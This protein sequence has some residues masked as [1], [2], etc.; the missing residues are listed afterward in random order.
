MYS[1]WYRFLV[2]YMF[3]RYDLSNTINEYIIIIGIITNNGN[4]VK[5]GSH[6]WL[7]S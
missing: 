4:N 3:L 2:N 7:K 5:R 6:A 1:W